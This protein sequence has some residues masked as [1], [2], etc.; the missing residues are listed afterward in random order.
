M[1]V[2]DP[3]ADMLTKIRNASMAKYEKGYSLFEIEGGN[4][5]DPQE[6]GLHKNL[7]ED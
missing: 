1:S 4:R 3:I 7:Q 6:R 5:E 2:S